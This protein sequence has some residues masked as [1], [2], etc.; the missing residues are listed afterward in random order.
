[1]NDPTAQRVLLVCWE[2]ADWQ[3][4]HPLLDSGRMP[5]LASVVEAGV[6]GDLLTLQP[7]SPPMLWAS[8]AT[9]KRADQHGVLGYFDTTADSLQPVNSVFVS[10]LAAR[11]GGDADAPR[12]AQLT[13]A[14][15]P[16]RLAERLAELRLD[17]RELTAA[18]LLSLV[19]RAAE[20]N[21]DRDP[22]L[23]ILATWLAE[24]TS[25]HAMAT[26]AMEHEPWDFAA[27]HYDAI[28]RFGHAFMQFHPPRRRG[29]D[30]HAFDL[31]QGVMDGVYCYCDMMLGRLL[32]LAGPE[33]T[34]IIM[35]DHGFRSSR[36]RPSASNRGRGDSSWHRMLGILAMRGPAVR[37]DEWV[38]GASL[39]DICPTVLAL[40]GLPI[41]RDMP[42]RPLVEAFDPQP[43]VSFEAARE[44]PSETADGGKTAEPLTERENAALL[45]H[46]VDEGYLQ[47]KQVEGARAAQLARDATDFNLALVYQEQG[48]VAEAAEVMQGLVDRRPGV[49]RWALKLAECRLAMGDGA[50]CRRLVEGAIEQGIPPAHAR[51]IMAQ[52]LI[53]ED[54]PEQALIELFDCEQLDP[55]QPGIHCE[56]GEVYASM[57][58]WDEA[59]RAY[60]KELKRDPDS[61]LSHT[62]LGRIALVNGDYELAVEELLIAISLW[63]SQHQAHFLLGSAL[64]KLGRTDDAIRAFERT[65]SLNPRRLDAHRNLA[66]IYDAMDDRQEAAAR[67]RALAE[68]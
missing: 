55:Q 52:V 65:L 48:R 8:V 37:R 26:W 45:D 56:I 13:R 43:A 23:A 58:R 1:M 40:F 30:Q 20:V 2:G 66:E 36:D 31:Y 15:S 16:A 34:V 63:Q 47:R 62:G 5:H 59:R 49:P 33:T 64:V 35:S 6:M 50:G 14:V 67:H 54:K 39:L 3:M 28:D 57:E 18:E 19:P 68:Q 25:I 11:F 46:L 41:G 42:G 53:A 29:I 44:P 21:Q 24:T 7:Q 9:G 10:N 51:R 32:A 17:P 22:G 27:V 4:I 38:W 60:A 12:Y 61:A